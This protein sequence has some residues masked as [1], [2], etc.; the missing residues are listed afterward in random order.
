MVP[1]SLRIFVAESHSRINGPTAEQ[2]G[3]M[4]T[5]KDLMSEP[6]ETRTLDP[7]IKSGLHTQTNSSRRKHFEHFPALFSG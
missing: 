7:R 6:G 5:T 3:P 2:N 4:R 1:Q